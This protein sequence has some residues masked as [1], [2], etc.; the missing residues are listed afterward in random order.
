M[1]SASLSPSLKRLH[2]QLRTVQ[3]IAHIGF[4]EICINVKDRYITWSEEMCAILGIPHDHL[5]HDFESFV[6]FCTPGTGHGF[7]LRLT[8]RQGAE[9]HLI[10]NVGLIDLTAKCGTCIRV[11]I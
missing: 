1:L 4:W 6:S 3:R 11:G 8:G 9:N 7:S 10:S 5:Q 2:D